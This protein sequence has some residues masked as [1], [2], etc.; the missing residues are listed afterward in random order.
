[1][2]KH[3]S[4]APTQEHSPRVLCKAF[5]SLL[6]NTASREI[7]ALK[8]V[9]HIWGEKGRGEEG[10]GG[11]AALQSPGLQLQFVHENTKMI[12]CWWYQRHGNKQ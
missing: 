11:S 12:K 6:Q 9:H 1:M 7:A 5:G 10:D 2:L 4:T 3:Q 8:N